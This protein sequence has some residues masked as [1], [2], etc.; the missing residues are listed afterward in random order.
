MIWYYAVNQQRQGPVATEELNRL[1]T[2]GTVT[3]D[4]LVW[5]QGMESWQRYAEVAAST[6]ELTPAPTLDGTEVCAVSGRRY[7]RN[8]MLQYEG[9]WIAAEHRDAF[10]Q[11]LREGVTAPGEMAYAGFWIRFAA[12]FIDGILLWVVNMATSVLL[13]LMI[14]GSGNVLA[15][16][17]DPNNLGAFFLY[18]GVTMLVNMLIALGYSWFMLAR[19]QATLGKLALGLKVVRADGAKLTSGRIVGRHFAEWI[20]TLTLLIGY[21]MAGFD[22]PEKRALH[23]RI[24]DTRVIKAR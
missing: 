16:K 4:T 18:Q 20:S 11:R 12:K 8:Q 10:F 23:D 7:P 17:A 24:C 5:R 19:Y 6:P 2:A 15:P 3:A 13:M 21:I 14:L 22:E 1:L 9:R